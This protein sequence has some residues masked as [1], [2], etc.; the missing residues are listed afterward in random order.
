MGPLTRFFAMAMAAALIIGWCAAPARA[1]ALPDGFIIGV[2]V[3]ELLSQEE[4][5]VTYYDQ[6]GQPADALSILASCGVDHVRLRVWNDPYDEAGHGYGGGNID[7]AR[8]AILSAR[9]ARCG[10]KT[11][12]D[13]HYSDF[14]ADPSR[15]IEPKA[16]RGMSLDQ[17]AAALAGY[18]SRALGCVLDAGGAVDMIQI[19]NETT[20]GIAGEY[21]MAA[22]ARLISAG[23]MAARQTAAARGL[24]IEVCV[25]LTD[26]NHPGLVEGILDELD[27]AG[28]MYDAVGLSYY[29]YW[30]GGLD[31]LSETIRQIRSRG[32]SVFIAE[33][34]WPFTL[35]DGDGDP[36]VIGYDP[37]GYPVTPEGQVQA[38]A[39][40]LATAADAGAEGVFYWG[41][42]WTPVSG[43]LDHNRDLWREK[44]SGWATD[45][46]VA[47]DPDHVPQGGGD[48]WDNQ[49]LF[50]FGGSP[51]PILSAMRQRSAAQVSHSGAPA[52]A[53]DAAD[54]P[55]NLVV[56]PGFDEEDRSM[57]RAASQTDDIPYD[58]QDFVNDAHSGSVAF[59]YWSESDM[60]FTLEQTVTGLAPGRYRASLWSQGGDMRDASLTLY[61]I[62]DGR[63]YECGFM[64]TSWADWQNPV[65]E[66][67]T[68][69]GD[70]LIIG[71][72]VR[73]GA[74]G[75]G[76]LDDFSL[77]RVD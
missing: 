16:W 56:N 40:V 74:R 63:R 17:K 72:E 47:Y 49:A 48:A 29:P 64:N 60:A 66:G 11:L 8:A 7:A 52:P 65:I 50:D 61:V 70:S 14:W 30:H 53:R 75:W 33:T 10:M 58:Y 18:T 45:Y 19:G 59:H 54:E 73:C 26:I 57:W 55:E 34:A 23:C 36:N 20:T 4:S 1:E 51:L 6:S 32:K 15:Q 9:A 76:T 35:E 3:S 43:D 37:G 31:G 62:A 68:L 44:G 69:T 77:T 13:L 12:L 28:A 38:W 5:G 25:H 21:D 46:A 24:Q 27:R 2:D 22:M 42:I 67:I 71:A 39:D 41:G